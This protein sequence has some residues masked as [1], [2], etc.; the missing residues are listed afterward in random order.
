MTLSILQLNAIFNDKDALTPC[1]SCGCIYRGFQCECRRIAAIN[2]YY[3]GDRIGQ[4]Y[5]EATMHRTPRRAVDD[6][7]FNE[8]TGVPIAE[9]VSCYVGST[10]EPYRRAGVVQLP[11]RTPP[12]VVQYAT[13]PGTTITAYPS[14]LEGVGVEEIREEEVSHATINRR[15]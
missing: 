12:R 1:S 10:V 4:L 8:S 15:N 9:E 14:S 6:R 13:A 7:F 3:G 11:R 5:R 2:E